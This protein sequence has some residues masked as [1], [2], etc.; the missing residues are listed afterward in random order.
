MEAEYNRFNHATWECEYR[1]VF[2]PKSRSCRSARSSGT[3]QVFHH[4]ARRK[5]A[6]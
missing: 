1:V 2:T 6:A 4:L 5:R 3:G